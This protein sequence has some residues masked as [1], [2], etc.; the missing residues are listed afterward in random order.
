MTSV[1]N[2][3][4][5]KL[6]LLFIILSCMTYLLLMNQDNLSIATEVFLVNLFIHIH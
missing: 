1:R 5:E 4:Q 2:Y 3:N 6:F